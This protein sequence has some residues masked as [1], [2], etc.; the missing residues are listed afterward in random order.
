MATS[1][2]GR[3]FYLRRQGA[4]RSM[5]VSRGWRNRESE[6]Q[7]HSDRHELRHLVRRSRINA[8]IAGFDEEADR[9]LEREFETH[10][11]IPGV[12]PAGRV[13]RHVIGVAKVGGVAIE[14]TDDAGRI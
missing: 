7:T 11:G 4:R 9:I 14:V 5:R 1:R 3:A 12:E 13:M 8:L 2:R 10:P 6:P